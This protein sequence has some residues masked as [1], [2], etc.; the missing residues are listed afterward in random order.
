M[1]V[2]RSGWMSEAT[3]FGAIGSAFGP[4]FGGNTVTEWVVG[5]TL[6]PFQA[7]NDRVMVAVP[8]PA[9]SGTRTGP[10]KLTLQ[11][12][13]LISNLSLSGGVPFLAGGKAISATGL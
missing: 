5:A 11:Q 8:E 4:G 10:S 7:L 1:F 3:R 9:A 6:A 12:R 13:S 2:F